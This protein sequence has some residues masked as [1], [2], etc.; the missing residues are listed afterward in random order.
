MSE[1]ETGEFIDTFLIELLV[2][3]IDYIVQFSCFYQEA[4]VMLKRCRLK[5][6]FRRHR[7]MSAMNFL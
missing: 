4:I 6:V 1:V 7:F 3:L 5:M 2:R